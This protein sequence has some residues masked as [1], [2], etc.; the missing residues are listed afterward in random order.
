[1]LPLLLA[2][3]GCAPPELAPDD[4]DALSR[5]LY[6]EQEAATDAELA[7]GVLN[8]AAFADG[9]DFEDDDAP[10]FGISPLA[11]ADV[12]ALVE[13]D[14]DPAA[15]IGVGVFHLSPHGVD[16]HAEVLAL[17][18]QTVVEPDAVS[19]WRTFEEGD[20]D[21]WVART[22]TRAL[23]VND[24]VRE[25]ALYSATYVIYKEMRWVPLPDGWAIASRS[26]LPS[27]TNEDGLVPIYQSYDLDLYVQRGGGT[28]RWHVTWQETDVP[29]V[30]DDGVAN[31]VAMGIA[32]M[33]EAWEA[34]LDEVDPLP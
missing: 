3:A 26:W 27:P 12:E 30:S 21:C 22:C 16:P 4:I 7:E 8:L 2:W 14:R 11:R 32:D 31:V 19:F 15:T 28:L 17:A 29:G 20:A 34:Y 5:W 1:M 23:T 13:H 6:V 25:N 10:T 33:Y 18:D 24:V 9:L